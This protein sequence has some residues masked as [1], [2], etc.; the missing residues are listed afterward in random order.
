MI[1]VSTEALLTPSAATREPL[2]ANARTGKPGSIPRVYRAMNLGARAHDGRRVRLE[3]ILGP[4]GRRTS[5]EAIARF[6][7]E[8]TGD[9]APVAKPARTPARRQREHASAERQLQ[10]AGIL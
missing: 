5:R 3:W 4:G 1:D 2:F 10:A 6:V 8:L 7:A 9:A